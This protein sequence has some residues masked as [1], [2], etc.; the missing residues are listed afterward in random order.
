MTANKG[1]S[2]PW[3]I[4]WNLLLPFYYKWLR[5]FIG[6]FL[7]PRFERLRKTEHHKLYSA[8]LMMK[9]EGASWLRDA[10][11]TDNWLSAGIGKGWA[12]TVNACFCLKLFSEKEQLVP[13][14]S[15]EG[16]AG[17]PPAAAPKH[18]SLTDVFPLPGNQ[19]HNLQLLLAICAS[20]G[21]ARKHWKTQVTP[22]PIKQPCDS[23]QWER[24]ERSE[25]PDTSS[26][27]SLILGRKANFYHI[28]IPPY[29]GLINFSFVKTGVKVR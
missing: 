26:C 18:C 22:L 8:V 19:I 10:M 11:L 5:E 6:S 24:Q 16:T 15:W 21:S 4:P 17:S 25:L 2:Y 20:S 7:S 14:C 12:K 27:V 28:C 3:V 9:H 29:M 13:V 23:L 1:C